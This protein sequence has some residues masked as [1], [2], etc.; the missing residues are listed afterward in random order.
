VHLTPPS[1]GRNPLLSL[2]RNY[3]EE[4]EK[5]ILKKEATNK[6]DTHIIELKP[7]ALV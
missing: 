5:D 7:F 6:Y 1:T 4:P 3:R 2:R